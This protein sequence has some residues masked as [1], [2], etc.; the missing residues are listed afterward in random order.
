MSDYDTASTLMFDAF[1][2]PA[3]HHVTIASIWKHRDEILLFFPQGCR[4]LTPI[5]TLIVTPPTPKITRRGTIHAEPSQD[6]FPSWPLSDVIHSMRINPN[7]CLVT[8]FHSDYR[9]KLTFREAIGRP[10]DEDDPS[11]A[12]LD[13]DDPSMAPPLQDPWRDEL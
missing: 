7:E 6:G 1:S 11:M 4:I 2:L 13:E 3:E 12:A 8:G 9:G 5:G 10:L